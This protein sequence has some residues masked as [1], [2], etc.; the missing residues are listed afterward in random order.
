MRQPTAWMFAALAGASL[1]I[2]VARRSADPRHLCI[3]LLAYPPFFTL[4]EY[5]AHRFV[6]HEL[7][8]PA[9]RA[10]ASHHRHAID[11]SRIF[12]PV[13]VTL[14]LALSTTALACLVAADSAPSVVMSMVLGYLLFEFSHYA[15]H[16]PQGSGLMDRLRTHHLAHH[17]RPDTKFGFV[18]A[19]WDLAFG[20]YGPE[21]CPSPW[22]YV[23]YPVLPFVASHAGPT[24]WGA[25]ALAALPLALPLPSLE[26]YRTHH[27]HP[28]NV[29]V[30]IVCVPLLVW[31]LLAALA[32][33]RL[34]NGLTMAHVASVTHAL[35][36]AATIDGVLTMAWM[37]A[38]A[39]HASRRRRAASTILLLHG[40]SWAVQILVGHGL[41][42][43]RRPA[44]VH[45][46]L[47]SLLIAPVA[48]TRDVREGVTS[49]ALWIGASWA[50]G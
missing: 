29:I 13:V 6:L 35:P 40:L 4:Q 30:H 38:L 41:L 8:G 42:E 22:L 5:L 7:A 11:V 39:S 16:L 37:L 2:H 17:S 25:I 45:S 24:D 49:A 44:L 9:S 1:A 46:F 21:R 34:A 3:T 36:H 20:T 12:V 50:S 19:A 31:S 23:P 10:H 27:A 28:G 26:D 14:F 43:G 33:V 47:P 15:A 18:C 32:R 48:I